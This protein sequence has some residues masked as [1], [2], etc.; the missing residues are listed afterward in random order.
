M[1]HGLPPQSRDPNPK[2]DQGAAGDRVLSE[3]RMGPRTSSV[4]VLVTHH[5]L[6]FLLIHFVFR[7]AQK[8][9]FGWL[10]KIL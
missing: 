4:E 3:S 9:S 6:P 10:M 2:F 7:G 1:I 5:P 8:S